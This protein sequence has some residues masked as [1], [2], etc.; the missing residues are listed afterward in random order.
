MRKIFF[1][2]CICFT[3][4]VQAQT[5]FYHEKFRPQF[6]FSSQKNWIND[7]NGL[8]YSNG[9]YHLFYQYNPFGNNWGHMSWGHSVSKDLVKWKQLPVAIR[10]ENGIMIF[11]GSIVLDNKNRSALGPKKEDAPMVAIYSGQDSVLQAQH[12]NLAYSLDNGKS[13]SKYSANPVLDIKMKNFRD[14][15]VFWHEPTKRWIMS[16]AMPNEKMISFYS[17][18]SLKQWNFEGDFGPQSDT[19]GVWEC[20]DLIQVPIVGE[21]NK[22]KWVLLVSQNSSMQYFV[23]EFNGSKFFNENPYNKIMRPDYGTDYYAAIS[24]KTTPDKIPTTI[25]WVSN[26]NY[27]ND[28]PTSPWRGS[29]SIP[30][31]LAVKKMG[32]EWILVQEPIKALRSMRSTAEVLKEPI[33]VTYNYSTPFK[34]QSYEMEL[35]IRPGTTSV[36]GVKIAVGG[37]HYF[38]IK[39][40]ASI[41]QLYIDRSNMPSDFSAQYQ[42]FNIKN[43]YLKT[44]N[45][46]VKLHIFVD[47]SI[48]EIFANNG[49]L[50]FTSLI[51]PD[52]RDTGIEFFSDGNESIFENVWFWPMKSIWKQK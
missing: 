15:N 39:Y 48:V 9:E 45:D 16:V 12:Q 18:F 49:E 3:L 20:P 4:I 7:P 52:E 5:N 30:R 25:G 24:Y 32:S 38:M 26:W 13:W 23:G 11:S 47:K 35:S 1:L 10:E 2:L 41:E 50:V 43:A 44:I 37:N 34:G 40:D 33:K 42:Y 8:I 22:K 36:S 27:A 28:V 19:S 21:P 14:P 51:F 31:K 29:M 17:S 6:H 46:L